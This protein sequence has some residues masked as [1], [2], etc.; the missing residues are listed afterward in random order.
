MVAVHRVGALG[1]AVVAAARRGRLD[2]PPDP[3]EPGEQRAVRGPLQA[4]D[5]LL[6]ADG[7]GGDEA[8]EERPGPVSGRGEGVGRQAGVGGAEGVEGA[9]DAPP[10]VAETPEDA[11]TMMDDGAEDMPAMAEGGGD[12]ED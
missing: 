3:G 7:A 4:G 2:R 5:E 9:P 10:D 8:V 6:L 11:G 12:G 1:G